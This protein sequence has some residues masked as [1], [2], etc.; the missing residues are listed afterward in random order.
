V[1]EFLYNTKT[2]LY[3][4]VQYKTCLHQTKV[5]TNLPAHKASLEGRSH[6][7]TPFM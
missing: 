2:V 5:S 4:T 1:Q 3:N 6:P 7:P